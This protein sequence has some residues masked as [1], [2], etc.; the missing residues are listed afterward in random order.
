MFRP[1]YPAALLL[2]SAA[3]PVRAD[4]LQF[5]GPHASAKGD[6]QPPTALSAADIAWKADLPGRGLSSPVIVGNNIFITAAILA[7]VK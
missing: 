1:T 2:L 6:G 3:L 4:W 5:R 7:L